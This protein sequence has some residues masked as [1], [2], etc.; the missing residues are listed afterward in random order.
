M[1]N[2]TIDVHNL[3][4]NYG[5]FVAVNNISFSVNE[6][7]VFGFL[8]PNGAGKSTTIQMLAG[9]SKPSSGNCTVLD[10]N[11]YKSKKIYKKMGI[12]F[13]EN[14]LYKRLTGKQNLEFFSSLYNTDLSY[15]NGLLNKFG[16]KKAESK[17][18]SNY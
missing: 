6:G 16:L 15:I 2:K 7:E 3:T 17:L 10:E 12:V 4:K 18:V 5:E 14:T 1:N 11:T 13:E 9:L 8:G